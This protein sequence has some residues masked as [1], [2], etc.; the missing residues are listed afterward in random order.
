MKTIRARYSSLEKRVLE[1]HPYDSPCLLALP[2]DQGAPAF[3]NWVV[4]S[5]NPI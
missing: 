4:A 1:L 5:S 3:L 2:V